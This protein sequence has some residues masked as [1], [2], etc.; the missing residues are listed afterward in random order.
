M[1]KIA[2]IILFSLFSC[3]SFQEIKDKDLVVF[4]A[5]TLG[6]YQSLSNQKKKNGVSNFHSGIV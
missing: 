6:E 3:K 5:K 2:I 4:S 1:K